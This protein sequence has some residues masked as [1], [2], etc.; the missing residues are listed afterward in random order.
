[1]TE[2]VAY[3]LKIFNPCK[4]RN[5]ASITR[6]DSI[7]KNKALHYTITA[8]SQAMPIEYN[9]GTFDPIDP[10]QL[11]GEI[12]IFRVRTDLESIPVDYDL[13]T[14]ILR[15]YSDNADLIGMYDRFRI[16]TRYK[17]NGV[18]SKWFTSWFKYLDPCIDANYVSITPL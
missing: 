13:A 3:G 15:I 14:G 11:C 2:S 8:G 12:Y 4:D 17:K 1:M 6:P 10:Y 18:T 16:Q 7:S 5:F 9:V